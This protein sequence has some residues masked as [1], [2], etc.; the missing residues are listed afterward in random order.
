[1]SVKQLRFRYICD[2]WAFAIEKL[3]KSW[4]HRTY[5]I[6]NYF[7]SVNGSSPV[8]VLTWFAPRLIFIANVGIVSVVSVVKEF[9][10]AHVYTHTWRKRVRIR[11]KV[12]KTYSFWRFKRFYQNG[13]I[14]LVRAVIKTLMTSLLTLS[15]VYSNSEW[16][17]L[18]S[19]HLNSI[20]AGPFSTNCFT[21]GYPGVSLSE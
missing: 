20:G 4:R 9:P 13:K 11:A 16:V 8:R 5:L 15:K 14:K 6:R 1:M 17:S 19:A 18:G 7:M 10:S 21:L 3:S 2:I 12:Q